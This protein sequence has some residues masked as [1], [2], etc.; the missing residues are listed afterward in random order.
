MVLVKHLYCIIMS[1]TAQEVEEA[2]ASG[3]TTALCHYGITSEDA[4]DNTSDNCRSDSM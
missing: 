2:V 4:D 3:L 1:L